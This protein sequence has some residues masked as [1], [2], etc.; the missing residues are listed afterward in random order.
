M[1]ISNII[2]GDIAAGTGFRISVFVSGCRNNC[3]GCFNSKAFDF[4][5]G[6]PYT[7][8]AEDAIVYAVSQPEIA[9][10]TLL[11]GEPLEPEN[12]PDIL[13]LIKRIKDELPTKTIWLFTGRTLTIDQEGKFSTSCLFSDIDPANTDILNEILHLVD[14]VVDGPFEL[15][16]KA[17]GDF[18]GSTNQRTIDL[19]ETI[20]TKEF[21]LWHTSEPSV[22][23]V[24]ENE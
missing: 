18:K 20:R 3:P 13:K 1:N 10:L 15:Q 21:V 23:D 5:Y 9:G 7:P 11:G 8:E 14:V 6:T 12:Q 22:S 24:W 4:A 19:P 16:N 2:L 17:T